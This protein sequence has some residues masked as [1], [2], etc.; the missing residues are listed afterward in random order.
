[1]VPAPPPA[2]AASPPAAPNS[3]R[4]QQTGSSRADLNGFLNQN[5]VRRVA[6]TKGRPHSARRPK[7][8]GGAGLRAVAA[9]SANAEGSEGGRDLQHLLAAIDREYAQ[10]LHRITSGWS[11]D[12]SALQSQK[13]GASAMTDSF[14]SPPAAA[15]LQGV[16]DLCEV[17]C[18]PKA[19]LDA[20]LAG[21]CR[22]QKIPATEERKK[23]FA[24]S[25]L[26]NCA[27][28]SFTMQHS[29]VGPE[30]AKAIVLALSMGNRFSSLNLSCNSLGDSGVATIALALAVHETLTDVD[31][32]ANDISGKGAEAIFRQLRSNK[33]VKQLDLSSKPGALRNRF[34]AKSSAGPLEELL[35]ENR[36]L[37]K[38][39]LGSTGLGIEGT[40][41]I[42]RGLV[43]NT[44]LKV[45][46][47]SFCDIGAKGAT[48]IAD[49]LSSC[50]LEEL[51]LSD[52]HIMDEG[53]VALANA[54][55]V[56]PMPSKA[57]EASCWGG[58]AEAAMRHQEATAT[59]RRIMAE[60][61]AK[62]LQEAMEVQDSSN[63][64]FRL[65]EAVTALRGA[66]RAA[67]LKLPKLKVLQLNNSG[68]SYAGLS[69][70]ED[71]MQ[72]NWRVEKLI[73]D[74]NDH[75]NNGLLEM[76]V[77]LPITL[78]LRHLG[79]GQ[80]NIGRK[81]LLNLANALSTNKVLK[82]LMLNGNKFDEVSAEALAA[83]LAGGGASA[84]RYLNLNTCHLSDESGTK[85]ALGVGRHS[86]LETL[87]LRDNSL[88]ETAAQALT[89]A[90]ETNSTVTTLNLELNSIDVK[91]LAKIKQLL[92]RNSRIR[93][94]SLPD[95]YRKRIEELK[96]YEKEVEVLNN[97][98]ARNH[99]RK[100]RA[101]WK[102]AGKN[103]LLI[104]SKVQEQRRVQDAEGRIDELT[105]TTDAV[106]GEIAHLE[107]KLAEMRASGDY[108]MSQ[109]RKRI[110]SVED[111]I[112]GYDRNID[113]TKK[114]LENFE[115]KASTDIKSL[116]EELDRALKGQN[117]AALL[118]SAAQRNLDSFTGSLKAI[119]E[120]IAGGSNPRQRMSEV[121]QQDESAAK[122]DGTDGAKHHKVKSKAG[123][124]KSAAGR[125]KSRTAG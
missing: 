107:G 57:K 61:R 118:A 100:R 42:A 31:L 103:Q 75:R 16:V 90:M 33:R 59:V 40:A 98:L 112:K 80:C 124:P 117:S 102:Q 53:L 5:H 119:S 44:A 101:L 66:V 22:D 63:G 24:E 28:S 6:L 71:A 77:A 39:S 18:W 41:G 36:V 9:A 72:A 38:L 65:N 79:L 50:A 106:E 64:V 13:T 67:E 81:G 30:C 17:L 99:W 74:Q 109:L 121:K 52:N 14:G 84:L 2:L 91:A 69:R 125:P 49:A 76:V 4:E 108:E 51:N 89:E 60:M 25:M 123:R 73:L 94:K 78:G 11:V 48:C 120:D 68:G 86:V 114:L 113:K 54:L 87:L 97:V 55:G 43:G 32:S 122:S 110:S 12:V 7:S 104:D 105:S 95:R 83:C 8:A 3:A 85:L 116:Q 45:L 15:S 23:R 47:L 26:T 35:M 20:M 70:L 82:S 37:Y 115:A 19:I 21:K 1:M 111:K 27:G 34:V 92:A 58:S 93:E 96:Q 56:L 29:S 62:D 10:D 88:Q 46:D